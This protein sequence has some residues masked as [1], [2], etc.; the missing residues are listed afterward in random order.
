MKTKEFIEKVEELGFEVMEGKNSSERWIELFDSNCYAVSK[1]STEYICEI[2]TTFNEFTNLQKDLKKQLFELLVE[3]SSTPIEE[4]EEKKKYYLKH[5][6]LTNRFRDCY[7]NYK[8]KYDDYILSDNKKEEDYKTQFTEQEIEEIKQKF[9][10]SLD[11]FEI[12]EVE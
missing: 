3:Y 7:L 5:K 4:R 6:F 9:N 12:I 8:T 10:T 11:D 1:V 2:V